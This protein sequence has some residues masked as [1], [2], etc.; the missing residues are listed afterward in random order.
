MKCIACFAATLAAMALSLGQT[1]TGTISGIVQDQSGAVVPGA[2]VEITD[3][4]NGLARAVQ[5]Q[6]SGNFSESA[7]PAG[8]YRVE[9]SKTGFRTSLQDATVETGRVT[10]LNVHLELGRANEVVSVS[11]A[12]PMLEYERHSIDGVIT[13]EQIQN[14]PLNGRS[15]LQLAMLEPGVAV[16][17]ASTSQYNALMQVSIL[18]GSSDRTAITVDGGNVRNSLDGG[19]GMNF[20]QEVVQEFQLSS[21]DFDLSTPITSVGAINIVTRTGSNAFHGA[22]YFYFRDHNMA[23]YPG[24]ARD[25]I[26][27]DPFFARRS[28][29]FWL[30]GP[31]LRN[32]L[33]FFV[34][35]ETMNQQSVVTVH[36]DDPYF[37]P[38]DTVYGSPYHGKQISARLDYH[39]NDR[40]TFYIRYSHDGNNAFGPRNIA[41]LPSNWLSNRNWADQGLLDYTAV[42]RPTLINDF[43][44]S[45][46]YWSNRNLLPT[47]QDCPGCIGLG[48]PEMTVYGTNI[49]FGD[50][51]NA[52]QG[53]NLRRYDWQ[54]TMTWQA[55]AHRVKFGGYFEHTAGTGFWAYADPAAG[56]VYSP[57]IVGFA[58]LFLPPAQRINIPATFATTQDLL[59]LPLAGFAMGIGDPSQPPPYNFDQA[60]SNDSVHVFIQDT[61]RLRPDFTLN[62]GLA[63]SFESNLVNHD[64]KKPAYLVPLYGS[65]LSATDNNYL[66]FS[67]S[68]GFAWN[69]GGDNKTVI[70]AGAGVYYDSQ[71]LFERLQERSYIGPLGNGRVLAYGS[72]IPNPIPGIPGAPQGAPIDYENGPTHFTLG[73][74]VAILPAI[75]S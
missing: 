17:P 40:N 58:N 21:A 73:D 4:A 56:I 8:L 7:L 42:L 12:A 25:P 16:T 60:K 11:A 26:D 33:F 34:N 10:T 2:T 45:Y 23:A 24:L 57:E 32:K 37:A 59:A 38:L 61:W 54:D 13:R 39:L 14:L 30:G 15:F 64:M 49:T 63:W 66:N 52:P 29:G 1:P 72:S 75:S 35:L 47:A 51:E 5:T 74:L 18:G 48:L 55:G 27:L 50:T 44:F 46:W 31:V 28:P 70:R 36:P 69:V 67:P 6:P 9:I 41:T 53:R 3:K 22:G 20:S 68:L 71:L 62:Y 19:T 43:R 65:D